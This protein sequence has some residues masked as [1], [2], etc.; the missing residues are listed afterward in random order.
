MSDFRN[1]HDIAKAARSRLPKGEWDYLTGGAETEAS[2]R[3]NRMGLDTLAFRPRVLNDVSTVDTSAELLGRR[4]RIPVVLAP[5]GSIERTRTWE[6]RSYAWGISRWGIRTEADLRVFGYA[7]SRRRFAPHCTKV[8]EMW[9]APWIII[10]RALSRAPEI[11]TA[12]VC[13]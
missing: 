12:F 4:L 6:E 2:L 10:Q 11:L 1:L 5:I 8:Y 13:V 9:S 3:R 7:M